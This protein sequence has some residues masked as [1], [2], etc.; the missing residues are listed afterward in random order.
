MHQLDVLDYYSRKDVQN[1]IAAAAR[2]REVACSSREGGYLK[3]PDMIQY[4]GDVLEKVR[5]GAVAFH[6]SVER[7]SNP[8][9]ITAGANLGEMRT[10]WDMIIDIDS[11]GKLEHSRAAA[12]AVVDFLRDKGIT[13]TV[14]FSGRRG[15][16]IAVAWEA[17]PEQADF[18][19]TATRYPEAFQ[20]LVGFVRE[21]V[22]ERILEAL[23]EEEGGVT[24]LMKSMEGAKELSPWQFV[25]IEQ[26][27]GT[28]HLFRAPYSLHSGTWMVSV[29]VKLFK[30]KH[31]TTEI[32]KPENVQTGLPFLENKPEEAAHFFMDALDWWAKQKQEEKPKLPQKTAGRKVRIPEECFPPCIKTITGGLEDGRKRSLFTLVNFLKAMGWSDE[33]ITKKV[34]EVNLNHPKGPLPARAIMTHLRYHLRKE[35]SVPPANCSNADYYDAFGICK[36]DALCN[37]KQIKNPVNYGIRSYMRGKRQAGRNDKS[38]RGKSIRRR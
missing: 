35:T 31:F 9:A 37:N 18:Q 34:E 15:F 30:L 13:P 26:N 16:H 14:K 7:W 21:N 6:L 29:P 38:A 19:R 17:F 12:V 23:V 8:L 36:P 2:G 10:G 20:A 25:E 1:S 28:R 32:A 22:K 24:A 5:R 4:P 11:K 33:E 27:W 3:R